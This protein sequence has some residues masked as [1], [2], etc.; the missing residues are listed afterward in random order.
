MTRTAAASPT[1]YPAETS[2]MTSP[3]I[4]TAIQ[5]FI[6]ISIEK[7]IK[8]HEAGHTDQ[9]IVQ[10]ADILSVY[11][12][13]DEVIFKL[14][15]LYQCAGRTEEALPLLRSVSEQSQYY[16]DALSMLGMTLG[17]RRDFAGGADCLIRVLERDDS[18][19]ECYN[20][21]SFFMMEL[22]RP[23]EAQNY[24]LRSIQ[25]APDHADTYNYLG[26]LYLRY[27]R[28]GEASEQYRRVLELQPGYAS[29]YSNLAW[30]ATL[31]GRI[32]DAVGFYR[33]AL[34]L[35][36]DFRIA[37]DN[38]LF[39]L[40]YTDIFTPEQVRDEHLN[41]AEACYAPVKDNPVR[42]DRPK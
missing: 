18:R 2:N 9:A 35:Q 1:H 37:A 26:N 5:R 13:N 27:W 36:P 24:L 11:P 40:N 29:A 3:I 41:L 12:D 42:H 6:N 19:I 15:R 7:V 22:S 23:E 25:V 21:L 4:N 8:L 34:E 31:E 16:T 39:A 30:I 32:A 20:K 17:D 28:L 33:T 10:F 38:F 14:A